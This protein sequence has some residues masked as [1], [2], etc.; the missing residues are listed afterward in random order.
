[1]KKNI[2]LFALFFVSIITVFSQGRYGGIEIG[3]KG[4]KVSVV[5]VK[6]IETGQFEII[7]FWTRNTAITRGVSMIVEY[8]L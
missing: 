3:G 4:I 1:M 8:S 5:N 2:T 7:K 6:D